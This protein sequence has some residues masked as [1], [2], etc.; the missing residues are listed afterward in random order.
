MPLKVNIRKT[1]EG[2]YLIKLSGSLDSNTAAECEGK[3]NPLLVSGTRVV[4]FDLS[5]LA[6]ISSMGL[7]IILATRKFLDTHGGRLLLTHLQPP[8]QKVIDLA[9]VLPK[10]DIF[11]TVAGADQFL[12][13]LE[14]K[15]KIRRL[16]VDA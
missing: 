7:R 3:L 1:G 10:T 15:E 5:E 4:V 12:D 14:R 13:A 11:N 9:D 2:R 8:I 16:D 6:Y